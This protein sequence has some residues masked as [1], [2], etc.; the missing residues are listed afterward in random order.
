MV[1]HSAHTQ[2]M[3]RAAFASATQSLGIASLSLC[4]VFKLYELQSWSETSEQPEQY[5]VF[6]NINCGP[7]H[8]DLVAVCICVNA[9]ELN[10]LNLSGPLPDRS[11][12]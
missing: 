4:D 7:Y 3:V 10:L 5:A 11:C 12:R 6:Q 9:H 1:P 2:S 8:S